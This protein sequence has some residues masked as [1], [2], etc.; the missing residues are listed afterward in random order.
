M[1]EDKANSEKR[2]PAR[3]KILAVVAGLLP[4]L[5]LE[6]ALRVLG[7]GVAEHDPY[8]EFAGDVP[9]FERIGNEYHTAKQRQPFLAHQKFPVK[10]FP[11]TVR[12]FCFGGSTV[13][14][15]P[16]QADTAFPKWLEIELSARTVQKRFEVINCGGISYASYRIAPMIREVMKYQ[17]DLVILATGHNE[18]LEDRTYRQIKQRGWIRRRLDSIRIVSVGRTLIK[19]NKATSKDVSPEFKTRLDAGNGYASYKRDPEWQEQVAQQFRSTLNDIA[20]TCENSQVPLMLVRL[21]SNLRD[22]PPFKSSF[23]K[24]LPPDQEREWMNHFELGTQLQETDYSAALDAYREAAKID[25]SH[26]LLNYRIARLE[27]RSGTG[28]PELYFRRALEEDVCPL[29]ILPAQLMAIESLAKERDLQLVDGERAI[30]DA[31]E[32]GLPGYDWYVDHVHPTIGGHQ[33]I[34]RAIADLIQKH[35]V[36]VMLQVRGLLPGNPSTRVTSTVWAHVILPTA[37]VAY[38]GWNSGQDESDWLMR[39]PRKA[40]LIL[41]GSASGHWIS[42]MKKKPDSPSLRQ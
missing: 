2:R 5:I 27:D 10:K 16:Y 29:R 18:F 8:A 22:C 11:H 21:G 7:V 9:V 32:D 41:S 4:L 19:G 1:K 23:R 33:I 42:T 31:S 36:P 13:H 26:A 3:F 35:D 20:D 24:D 34:A 15:R 28:D 38:V 14:G 30:M 40:R 37:G 17:P 39:S 25:D 6:L 12:I